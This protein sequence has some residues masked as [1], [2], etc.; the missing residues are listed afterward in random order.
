MKTL[1]TLVSMLFVSQSFGQSKTESEIVALSKKRAKWLVEG[2]LDSL[3]TL[4]DANSITVHNNGLIKTTAE[5]FE[6]IKNGR[7]I[8]KSIDIK[9]STVK[10]FGDT[11]IL[12]GKGMFNI[13]MNGQDMNYNMVYT[14]VYLKRNNQW[15]LISRQAVQQN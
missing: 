12:V 8:Y 13:A 10:D 2:K 9:E 11:A 4:Y 15:K 14:E 6:D 1:L 5:H 7:P 3:K